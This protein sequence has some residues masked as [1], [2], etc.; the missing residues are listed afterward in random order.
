M[1]L[2]S[3]FN[4]AIRS[5]YSA[6]TYR[7]V[8]ISEAEVNTIGFKY[9]VLLISL[10]WIPEMVKFHLGVT[11]ALKKD[12]P[13]FVAKLP[14]VTISNGV[15]TFDKPSPYVMTDEGTGKDIFIFDT[16]G[17]YTSLANTDAQLLLTSTKIIY[18]KSEYETREF[19]LSS[20]NSF[21]LTHEKI[22]SWAAW[23]NYISLLAYILIIPLAFVCRA[24]LALIYAVI[25]L[26]FQSILKTT[27]PFQ[28]IYRMAI[29]AMTPAYI[30]DKTLS[31]VDIDFSGWSLICLIAS[32]SYLYFGIRSTKTEEPIAP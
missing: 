30:A 28:S 9:L 15:A 27:L 29:F 21:V 12:L 20:I 10:L 22:Y 7:S 6:D 14:V 13:A 25:G 24:F 2:Y 1:N 3:F 5:F 32:L 19:S 17:Q 23:G 11:G 8:G 31:S 26:I 18:K 16:S 4:K